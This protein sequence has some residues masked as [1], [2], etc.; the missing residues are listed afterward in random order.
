MNLLVNQIKNFWES[1]E[2]FLTKYKNKLP[3][4]L[5]PEKIYV[6]KVNYNGIKIKGLFM[7][8]VI[9]H[10]LV[11]LLLIQVLMRVK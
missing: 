10:Y 11:F 8:I 6:P 4:D 3:L 7:N 9:P 5:K 2:V 1:K